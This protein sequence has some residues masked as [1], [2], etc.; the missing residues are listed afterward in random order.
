MAKQGSDRTCTPTQWPRLCPLTQHKQ[1]CLGSAACHSLFA[2][3]LQP[4]SAKP[5]VT[6]QQQVSSWVLAAG[7]LISSSP[8]LAQVSL[9]IKDK[10][11]VSSPVH[12]EF[13]VKGLTVKPASEVRT[14]SAAVRRQKRSAHRQRSAD[15]AFAVHSLFCARRDSNPELGTS[16]CW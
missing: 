6:K 10:A 13:A 8:A 9:N 7:I 12:V 5:A 14:A 1:P 4:C 15:K 11:T 16:I 2:A 3:R